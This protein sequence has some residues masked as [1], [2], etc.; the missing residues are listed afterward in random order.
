MASITMLNDQIIKIIGNLVQDVNEN[1]IEMSH[2]DNHPGL[3][4]SYIIGKE[5]KNVLKT[6]IKENPN[7]PIQ[8]IYQE[9]QSKI[10]KKFG[11]MTEAAALPEFP[12]VKSVLFKQKTR[13]VPPLPETIQDINSVGI[14]IRVTR[15]LE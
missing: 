1:N 2:E 9:Q 8:Q 6:T 11:D 5:F 13:L 10:I 3:T 15:V 7:R 4:T 12:S 14:T